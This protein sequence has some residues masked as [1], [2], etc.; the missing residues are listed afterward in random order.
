MP[1]LVTMLAAALMVALSASVSRAEETSPVRLEVAYGQTYAVSGMTFSWTTVRAKVKNIAYEK[2]VVLHYRD[3]DGTWKDHPLGFMGHYGTYDVFGGTGSTPTTGEFVLRYTVPG[4]EHWDNNKGAN[5]KIGTFK[6]V[7][8]GNVML[9]QATAHIGHEVGGGFTFTTSW[10]D[11]EIYVQN[12]SHNKRV[13]VRYSA[14]GGV[15][16]VDVDGSYVGP[17]RAVAGDVSGV[18]V[19]R[20]KTPTLNLNTAAGAFR[21]AVYYETRDPGPGFGTQFWDNNFAQDYVLDKAHGTTT[22]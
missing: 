17:E 22:E 16:W 9:K 4:Q 8:G 18:E 20:F 15:T 1:C 3:S 21:F 19:W 12:L 10:F 7:V 14:D 2:S 13:G 6:G 11:G 5:Y